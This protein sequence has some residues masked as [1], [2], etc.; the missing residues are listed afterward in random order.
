M[1]LADC[2]NRNLVLQENMYDACFDGLVKSKKKKKRNI[3]NVG[4][5][6]IVIVTVIVIVIIR[7]CMSKEINRGD[8]QLSQMILYQTNSP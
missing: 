2:R 5:R 7:L 3:F 8:P 4:T 6:V 1:R